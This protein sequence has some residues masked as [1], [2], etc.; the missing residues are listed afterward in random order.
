M[1]EQPLDN[2]GLTT[3]LFAVEANG[4]PF[5]KSSN[6]PSDA[7]ALRPNRLLLLRS[8]PRL[9]PGVFTKEDNFSRRRWH[10]V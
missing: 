5:T 10:Q 1:K 6:D 3:V 2:E 7:E 9:P 4:R 8:G